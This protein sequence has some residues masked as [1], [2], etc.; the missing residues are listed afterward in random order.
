MSSA[1]HIISLFV[2]NLI[3]IYNK[4][5]TVDLHQAQCFLPKTSP[6]MLIEN[7]MLTV[8]SLLYFI[9]QDMSVSLFLLG[10]YTT[11]FSVPQQLLM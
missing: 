2:V 10:S 7:S 8:S 1:F 6:S 4:E 3:K 5:G 9:C 11:S